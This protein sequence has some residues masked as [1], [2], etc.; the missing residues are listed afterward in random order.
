MN[1]KN[2]LQK[3]TVFASKHYNNVQSL[4]LHREIHRVLYYDHIAFAYLMKNPAENFWSTSCCKKKT[5][6]KTPKTKAIFKANRL[7][8]LSVKY[9]SNIVALTWMFCLHVVS[10]QV[11]KHVVQLDK[12]SPAPKKREYTV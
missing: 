4:H 8:V 1:L 5:H 7:L 6:Q 9:Y 2:K 12:Y 10:L 11:G 3:N